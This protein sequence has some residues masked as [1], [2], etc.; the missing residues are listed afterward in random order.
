MQLDPAQPIVQSLRSRYGAGEAA[1]SYAVFNLTRGGNCKACALLSSAAA[2]APSAALTLVASRG[3]GQLNSM[4]QI[5][6][7]GKLRTKHHR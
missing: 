1:I 3:V 5:K 7:N 6:I 4:G 2:G